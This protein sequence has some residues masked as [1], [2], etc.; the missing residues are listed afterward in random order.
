M[1]QNEVKND[2]GYEF[3]PVPMNLYLSMD[4]NCVF[5]YG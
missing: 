3:I 5:I 1:E 4:N 2:L